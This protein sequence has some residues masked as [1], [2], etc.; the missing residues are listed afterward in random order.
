M[1]QFD[2]ARNV[3]ENN[4]EWIVMRSPRSL[5]STQNEIRDVIAQM[6]QQM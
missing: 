5:S 4:L 2:S 1:K 6:M 3:L